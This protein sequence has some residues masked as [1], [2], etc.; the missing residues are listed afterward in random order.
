ML[1]NESKWDAP[2]RKMVRDMVTI[3]KNDDT[4]SWMLP[5]EISDEHEYS[6]HNVPGFQIYFDWDYEYSLEEPY[7]LNGDYDNDT[8]TMNVVLVI[9]PKYFPQSMYNIVADLND[10]IRHELEHHLQE[11]GYEE[12]EE[13]GK[14]NKLGINYYL[15]KMEIP[16]EMKGFRRIVKLRKQ[17]I[18]KVITDWFERHKNIHKFS[19]K[20][21]KKLIPILVDYYKKYYPN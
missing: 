11:W 16:A 19:E 7:Y 3:I 13:T 14:T 8:D 6:F 17:P 20:Q 12:E 9:N 1:L 21:L 15:K 5:S 10:I 4:G 18:E 2:V